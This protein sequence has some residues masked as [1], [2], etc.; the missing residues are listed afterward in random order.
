[1]TSS[2]RFTS[3]QSL[4]LVALALSLGFAAPVYAQRDGVIAGRVMDVNGNPIAGATVTVLSIE[5]GDERTFE[6]DEDGNYYG[7]G[8]RSDRFLVTMS[9]EGFRSQQQEVK[10]NFGMNTV[11]GVLATALAP[12]A[13]SATATTKRKAPPT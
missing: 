1:M 10:V 12:S 6:T 2:R 7:R 9:A 8:Y 13:A 11:D 4:G 3:F 5:R